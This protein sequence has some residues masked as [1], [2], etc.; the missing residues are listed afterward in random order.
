[1]P[2]LETEMLNRF[3]QENCMP[4]GQAIATCLKWGIENI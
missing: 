4:F 2:E 1:L 3:M